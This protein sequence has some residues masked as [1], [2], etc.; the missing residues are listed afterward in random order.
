MKP[1]EKSLTTEYCPNDRLARTLSRIAAFFDTCKKG[2]QGCEGYRKST[3]LNKFTG[4][5][6]DLTARG[7]IC[8]EK[9]VFSD[10]GCADGRV[11]ILMSY[12][13]RL[14]I[15][16]ELDPWILAEYEPL[17]KELCKQLKAADLILP[18]K[19]I[20][21]F[22]GS[23]LED[24][25]DQKI[26]D[27]TGVNFA[28]IDLFYTYITL[29]EIF[30]EKIVREAKDGALYLVYGF[31]QVLPTYQGLKRLVD[32]VGEQGIAALYCKQAL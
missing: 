1:L 25:T 22:P 29:H 16:I 30:A 2:Y 26:L 4:C 12:F 7:F 6:Q 5:V 11:N 14:S 3:D 21:L 8:P 13:V 32:D 24:A 18:P 20:M 19:N 10:L 27:E 9:T 15:G 17:E 31:N 28:D 23:S